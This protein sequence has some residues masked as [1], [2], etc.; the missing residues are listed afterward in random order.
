MNKY[1]VKISRNYYYEEVVEAENE[2]EAEQIV[3]DKVDEFLLYGSEL[4][5]DYNGSVEEI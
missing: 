1:L 2:E 5:D 4:Y 3:N